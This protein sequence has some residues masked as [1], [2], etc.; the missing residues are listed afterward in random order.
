MCELT[1]SHQQTPERSVR[2]VHLGRGPC[3]IQPHL[4]AA[5]GCVSDLALKE[6]LP[7]EWPSLLTG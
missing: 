5:A 2:P 6:L 7:T 1:S 3:T 4:H